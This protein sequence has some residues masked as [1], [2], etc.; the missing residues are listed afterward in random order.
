MVSQHKHPACIP[1]R[2]ADAAHSVRSH[3]GLKA[4][5]P[6]CSPD[7]PAYHNHANEHINCIFARALNFKHGRPSV[8]RPVGQHWAHL[9]GKLTHIVWVARPIH[10]DPGR[11]LW[12]CAQ[13]VSLQVVGVATADDRTPH[14]VDN[15]RSLRRKGT[16]SKSTAAGLSAVGA[17]V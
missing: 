5:P 8:S 9:I 14:C 15:Y 10:P 13:L 4:N 17:M 7:S 1:A 3:I 11:E 12:V 16:S 2:L 6:L